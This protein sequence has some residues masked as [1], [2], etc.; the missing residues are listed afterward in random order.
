MFKKW[1]L[2]LSFF[3]LAACEPV[4]APPPA[5]G[6]PPSIAVAN[7][8]AKCL[9]Q[10]F[11]QSRQNSAFSRDANYTFAEN[12]TSGGASLKAY[13][14]NILAMFGVV[15]T[16]DGAP[17]CGIT[18]APTATVTQAYPVTLN[19]LGRVV[20]TAPVGGKEGV[21]I[22]PYKGGQA[23]VII[24]DD[25]QTISLLFTRF[26]DARRFQALDAEEQMRLLEEEI[27]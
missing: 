20:K 7:F 26:Q 1:A 17:L 23:G 9:D 13:G 5:N 3:A 8:K 12:D 10:G 15:G 4:D 14:H 19:T 16:I 22:F 18:F 21:A 25:R 24:G 2:G 6:V 11:S 27:N